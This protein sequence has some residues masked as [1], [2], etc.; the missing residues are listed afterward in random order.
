MA[1]PILTRVPTMQPAC[2]CRTQSKLQIEAKV[3]HKATKKHDRH[4]PKKVRRTPVLLR[5]GAH[6]PRNLPHTPCGLQRNASDRRHVGASY[7]PLP[8][9]PPQFR[10]VSQVMCHVLPELLMYTRNA[11]TLLKGLSKQSAVSLY[12]LR[13]QCPQ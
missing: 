12:R 9:P 5:G 13:I 4:R 2:G 11:D 1:L 8:P 10:V 6:V 3:M 7:P